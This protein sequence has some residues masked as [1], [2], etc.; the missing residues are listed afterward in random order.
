MTA[1]YKVFGLLA[2]SVLLYAATPVHEQGNQVLSTAGIKQRLSEY[3]FFTG[4]LADLQPAPTVFPYEVNAPLFSDYAEKARFIHLPAGAKMG[5]RPD[6]SFDFPEGAAIIKNF[7]YWYDAAHPEKG[8]RIIETRLL[9]KETKGWKAL[10]YIWNPEQTDAVLEVA[11][12]T[13]P[14]AWQMANGKKQEILYTIPNLNQCKG[15]HSYDG[16][17]M[18]IGATTRQMNLAL[19]DGANQLVAFQKWGILDLPENFDPAE[20]AHLT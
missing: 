1:H 2:V 5:C 10:E 12:A 9:L 11:G 16:Q 17:F 20:A 8:R 19:A 7:F 4:A 13:T 14:V 6:A 15:C 3:T 18:P